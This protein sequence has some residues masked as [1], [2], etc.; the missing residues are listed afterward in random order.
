MESPVPEQ[1]EESSQP[2]NA[3][4]ESSVSVPAVDFF[5]S[6]PFVDSEREILVQTDLIWSALKAFNIPSP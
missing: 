1:K 4:T 5:P 6:D 2:T 3:P